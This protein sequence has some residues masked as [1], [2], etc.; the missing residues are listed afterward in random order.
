MY[1]L[2]NNMRGLYIFRLKSCAYDS[3]HNFS[4]QK[5]KRDVAKFSGSMVSSKQ[6]WA[7]IQEMRRKDEMMK[8]IRSVYYY[9][10][11]YH[12]TFLLFKF[13]VC[14]LLYLICYRNGV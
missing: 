4:Q 11:L 2:L 6:A 1:K 9:I 14:N 8:S 12:Q 5:A 7:E 3:V 10:S 13:E